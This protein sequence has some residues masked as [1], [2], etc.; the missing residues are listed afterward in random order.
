MGL[1][2]SLAASFIDGTRGD[3]WSPHRFFGVRLRRFSL[4]HLFL[5]QS[6][7]SPF[8]RLGDVGLFDLLTAV[9]ICRL[10]FDDSLIRRP[11]MGLPGWWKLARKDGLRREVMRFL[12]YTGDYF[13]KPEY[14]IHTR[15][16][17]GVAKPPPRTSAPELIMLAAD[18]MGWCRGSERW[19]WEL[20]PG[21]AYW[22]RSM[23]QRASGAD[24]DFMDDEERDFQEQMWA[25]GLRP[26]KKGHTNG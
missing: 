19:V 13:Q 17:P 14:C 24:V 2:P 21:R 11:R 23:A 16:V 26:Q 1:E 4:W 7:D 6:I 3:G 12:A 15:E 8:V 9:G 10:R 20:P 22:Y 5:L 18:V 25:A